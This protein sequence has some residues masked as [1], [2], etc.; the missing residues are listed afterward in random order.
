MTDD[1]FTDFEKSMSYGDYLKLD[2]LLACQTPVSDQHDEMLFV[3]IHQ[4]TEL[5]MKLMIHELTAAIRAIQRDDLKPA[6][7]MMTR[8]SRIQSQLIQSWDVL[9]TLT[10]SD[11]LTFRDQLGQSSGFQSYQY[12]TIEFA[13]G[14]KQAGMLKPHRHR[15]D[16]LEKLTAVFEAPS[17]YDESLLLLARRGFEI[18][19]DRSSRDWR[20]P[21]QASDGVQTV[22]R[23]I[24]QQAGTHWE[25]YELAEKLVDIEDW[26]RQWRF[27][28]LTTVE[29]IIGGKTGTGG[30]AG[31]AY[32]R[33]ATLEIRL[34]PELWDVR[35]DL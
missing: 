18:P 6:F 25:L 14:N 12:R 1:A 15:P 4:A 35:T 13:L 21:Y 30:T 9:S 26:F 3:V 22:W 32:L 2:E 5:W 11:Y 27:R 16:L 7:K 34:F 23:E 33:R 10:P 20:E 31:A 24:Y 8:V 29:R 28:H 19:A 17:I